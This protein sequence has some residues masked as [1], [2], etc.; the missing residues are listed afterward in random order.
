[1]STLA[2]SLPGYTPDAEVEGPHRYWL[3][4]TWGRAGSAESGDA[5]V[6]WIMLNPSTADATDDDPTIRRIVGFT[7][8][9]EFRTA[10]VVNLFAYRATRPA[11]MMAARGEGADIIGPSNNAA[12]ATNVARAGLVIAAWGAHPFAVERGRQVREMLAPIAEGAGKP[13]MCLG[14]TRAGHPQHPL[15]L[16]AMARPFPLDAP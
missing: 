6:V 13:I 3:S 10:V 12:I 9:F 8:D 15:Y 2:Q 5:P 7:R 11:D 14:R 4:R 1:M 16:P